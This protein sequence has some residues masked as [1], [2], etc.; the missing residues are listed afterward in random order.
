MDSEEP[1]TQ[2]TLEEI[3]PILIILL[4]GFLTSIFCLL[5]EIFVFRLRNHF[6]QQHTNCSNKFVK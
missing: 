6:R 2:A 1:N 5:A 4:T 3:L